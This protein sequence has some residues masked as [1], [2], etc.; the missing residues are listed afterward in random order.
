M[1]NCCVAEF[2]ESEAILSGIEAFMHF[3]NLQADYIEIAR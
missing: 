3:D 1:V 2:P